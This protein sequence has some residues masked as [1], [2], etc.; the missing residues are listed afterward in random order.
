MLARVS[1][2]A[3]LAGEVRLPGDKS[4]S[5]RAL[6]LNSVAAGR[7]GIS[8]LSEGEDVASSAACLRALGVAV[9]G[10]SV[11]G[12]GLDG[13]SP[14]AG[15]LDCGNSGT[16]MRLLAGLLAGQGFATTL[17]GDR[18]LSRRPMERVAAPLR[19]MGAE[20][21]TEPLTVGGGGPLRGVDWFSP[22]ASAQVKSAVLLAGLFASGRT[23]VTEPS[24]S[25]DHTELM[26][27]AMG[28]PIE[29]SGLSVAVERPRS[30]RPLDVAVPGDLSAAAFWLVAAGLHPRAEVRLPACGVNPTRAGLLDVL[31]RAGLGARVEHL[32]RQGAEPVADLWAGTA[33]AGRPFAVEGAEAAGVIDELPVLAVAA[34]LLPGTSR[35]A[36][37]AELRVKESDRIAVVAAGLRALG[38]D[39]DELPDGLEIRGGGRLQG[40]RV[41]PAGDHRVAMAMAVAGLLADGET[42]IEDAECV[43][44]SYPGFFD[45]LER[46]CSS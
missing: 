29:T 9:E 8:G 40:A 34:C 13:L 5:H 23:R 43:D 27:Q 25:R 42:E 21:G 44:V 36:G 46:L 45:Q 11:E 19:L 30:L 38:A 32:R 3:R 28:A 18:S 41:Q 35:I 12:R 37:A 20:V 15:A 17:V 16:T 6:L 7:A 33:A 2:P 14:P 22:V 10:D 39:L 1:R 24:L 26:L 31:E 4:V